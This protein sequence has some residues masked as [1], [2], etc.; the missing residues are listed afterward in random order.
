MAF[1][2]YRLSL[3]DPLQFY[4]Q[5][6]DPIA[7]QG[8]APV[9]A[10]RGALRHAVSISTLAASEP[11]TIAQRLKLRRQFR[12]LA[13]N[14]P[15]K[16]TAVYLGWDTD[17]ENNGWYVPDQGQL[18]DIDGAVGLAT[19][20][21]KVEN[22]VWTVAGRPRTHRR[23]MAIYMKDLR[24]GLW[25]RDVRRAIYS[26]DFSGMSTLALS[27]FGAGVS[28]LLSTGTVRT[29]TGLLLPAGAD[30]GQCSVVEGAVDLA[31]VS[32]EQLAASRNLGQVVVYDRR[33]ELTAPATGVGAAWE[34]FYGPDYPYNWLTA[35]QPM[36]APTLENGRCRVRFDPSHVDGWVIDE[37]TGTKW[38][39]QGK[40]T[41]EERGAPG[42][43]GEATLSSAS[44]VEYNE[45]RAVVQAIMTQSG[46]GRLEVFITLQRGWSGPRVEVYP[47]PWLTAEHLTE[48]SDAAIL[49]TLA[50]TDTD[51]SAIKIDS[52][53]V[54][55]IQATAMGTG[56]TGFFAGVTLGAETFTGEDWIILSRWKGTNEALPF[57]TCIAVTQAGAHA[58][59]TFSEEAYGVQRSLIE[60]VGG[61]EGSKLKA[62]YL[63]VQFGF[64]AQH[65]QQAMEAE[66]MTLGTGTSNTA[67]AAAS[68]GKAATATRTSDANPHTSQATWPNGDQAT[69]RVFARVKTSVKTSKL[70]ILA[71]TGATTGATKETASEAYV[72]VDLGEI[73][74]NNSTLEIHAWLSAAGTLSVDRVEAFL[75]E[76]RNTAQ[77]GIFEGGRDLGQRSLLDSRTTP[78]IVTRTV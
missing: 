62:G 52:G 34:E 47:A 65:A 71:K 72:W 77:G 53:S 37:W 31:R 75:V 10:V 4:E 3:N 69:Y 23:A 78:T 9:P 76:D 13:N 59:A 11:E 57:A 26:T 32:F 35:G 19:G 36:D 68:N 24:T 61:P 41:V 67:D 1:T 73:V 40:I 64:H 6:G 25:A 33:G 12:S 38:E 63:S 54:G 30:T 66:N 56:H 20:V 70:K 18:V 7:T 58:A 21:F 14:T 28:D 43:G 45:T 74:A 22:F 49:Y 16:L 60:I 15:M 51:D 46:G 48:K 55:A 29:A 44:L 2:F 5:I 8:G 17:P 42:V 27:Y 50:A 39:E